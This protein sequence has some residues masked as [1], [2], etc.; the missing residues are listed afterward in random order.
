M[1]SIPRSLL[2]L[3]AWS[4]LVSCS[5]APPTLVD[6]SREPVARLRILNPYTDKLTV[7]RFADPNCESDAQ[8]WPNTHAHG[9]L[10]IGMPP[11]AT[12]QV[13]SSIEF[14]V[15][16]DRSHTLLVGT[17]TRAFDVRYE[18]L[19]SCA[20]YGRFEPRAG[21]DY[22]LSFR[23]K[24]EGGRILCFATLFEIEATSPPR[25]RLIAEYSGADGRSPT[26]L[27]RFQKHFSA[28]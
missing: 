8:E 9:Q 7:I 18:H 13:R 2:Q 6:S 3:A 10:R 12:E 1:T 28:K 24:G 23:A 26:C 22:E 19:Y 21:H 4:V 25:R 11:T 27:S 17:T 15:P 5:T 14:A 16:A 20:A